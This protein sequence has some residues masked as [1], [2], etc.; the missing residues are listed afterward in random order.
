MISSV[1]VVPTAFRGGRIVDGYRSGIA[2]MHEVLL[3]LVVAT[4]LIAG[5]YY[6]MVTIGGTPTNSDPVNIRPIYNIA[7]DDDERSMWVSRLREDLVR[8]DLE[9]G[10]ILSA[11]PTS[12]MTVSA[13]AHSRDGLT[14]LVCGAERSVVLFRE[15]LPTEV[16]EM[17]EADSIDVAVTDDCAV[18]LATFN[19][20]RIRAMCWRRGECRDFYCEANRCADVV[21]LCVNSTCRHVLVAR[22]D[23]SAS[24]FDLEDG[25]VEGEILN[26]GPNAISVAW[27]HDESLVAVVT[28]DCQV[29]IYD[30]PAR[31]L[32]RQGVLDVERRSVDKAT[33][34]ISPDQ[35]RL[36]VS[37]LSDAG[38][39]L[40]D[41]ESGTTV[42]KLNCHGV[43]IPTVQFS[44]DSERL[45]SGG[46]DGAIRVWSLTSFSQLRIVSE[47]SK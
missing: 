23:A 38:L 8:I 10:E 27:S 46:Y 34:V 40:W 16:V 32:V 29:R 33:V 26:I 43:A 14:S 36:A 31:R 28:Q 15:G 30:V 21:G 24:F 6:F 35:R 47:N 39:V 19:D 12:G 18:A 45:F 44:T 4:G 5:V 2:A 22:R 42:G 11:F 3:L 7:V 20:G 1:Q 9:T 17:P 41:L 25:H 13:A 37:I